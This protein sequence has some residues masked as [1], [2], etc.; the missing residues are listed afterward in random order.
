MAINEYTIEE[1]KEFFVKLNEPSYRAKQTFLRIHKYLANDIEEFTELPKKLR[2]Y[3]RENQLFPVLNLSDTESIE[4]DSKDKGTQKFI[5]EYQNPKISKSR[6]FES[7]WIVSEKRRTACISS[8]SGC[9]LN[10]VFCATAKIPFKGNLSTWQILQQIYQM[11]RFRKIYV[12][13]KEKLTNVVF[14][15]MGE[16][17]Y[18]YDNVLKAA[19]ILNHPDGLNIGAR[20][21]TISTAGVIPGIERFISEKQ[22]F[23][24]AISLNNPFND[25]RSFL[26]DVNKKYPLEDLLKVVKKYTKLY[27]RNITFEYILIPNVNMSESHIKEILRI[28]NYIKN[29]KFNLIPLNTNFNQWRAPT[30]EEILN[31][32]Q[33]L[34][35]KGI[36]AFYRGSPG[37]KIHAACGMLA[38]QKTAKI[39]DKMIL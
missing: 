10:C 25:E 4:D 31:F 9:S 15:G 34:R 19:K 36:L 1:L 28:A 6:I 3:I 14:M 33:K 16:P 13:P 26:M 29:C 20:H 38:L 21:I 32:Q 22:P 7:V 18:N 37:K 35:E 8:Q 24:L 2:E 11:I 5:F 12:N 30:E 39:E 27:H 23:N 17:F